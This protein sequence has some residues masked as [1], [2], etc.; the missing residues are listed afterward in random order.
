M[1][2]KSPKKSSSNCYLTFF[3][4]T[5]ELKII[6]IEKEKKLTQFFF[7]FL[8]IAT[9][10]KLKKQTHTHNISYSSEQISIVTVY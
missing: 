9:L 5:N 2:K 7:N 6:E 8:V 3:S 10:I 4:S 1:R